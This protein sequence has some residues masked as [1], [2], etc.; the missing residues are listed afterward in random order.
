MI[1]IIFADRCDWK[2][3]DLLIRGTGDVQLGRRPLC[4]DHLGQLSSDEGRPLGRWHR[5][6][7]IR[8]EL[9]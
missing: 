2:V 6:Q 1:R 4:H 3:E 9:V 7:Q 8:N 5:G